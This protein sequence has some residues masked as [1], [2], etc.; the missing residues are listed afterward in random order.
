MS[1]PLTIVWRPCGVS[2]YGMVFRPILPVELTAL[3][4]RDTEKWAKLIR[5]KGIKGE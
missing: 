1:D 4:K 3:L 5:A 2:P